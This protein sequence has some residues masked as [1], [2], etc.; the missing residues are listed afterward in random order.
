MIDLNCKKNKNVELRKGC[1]FVA[2]RYTGT[3]KPV[4]TIDKII[5]ALME[6]GI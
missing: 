2:K 4:S 1:E 6:S 5:L 3:V